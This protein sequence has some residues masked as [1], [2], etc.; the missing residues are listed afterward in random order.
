MK[1][2]ELKKTLVQHPDKQVRF[3]LPTGTKIPPHAHVTEVARIDK[4][5]I[6]CGGTF[7]T[8]SICRLQTWF[9]DDTDHRLTS[10]K[11]LAILDKAASFLE[12]ENLEV[13][14]EH[15]APFISQFP[16]SVVDAERETL[17]VRL[18]T[19]HTA[20][21]AEDKCLPPALATKSRLLTPIPN[22]GQTKCCS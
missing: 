18:G 14:V 9:A 2:S 15:E 19:K 13:D 7:R 21:L 11:L 10:G 1:L 6:D 20:C 17:I 12:T 8:E 22:L 16:L 3:V 4:R 5:Y